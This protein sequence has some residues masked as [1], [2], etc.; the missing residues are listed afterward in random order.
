[1]AAALGAADP[2]AAGA[3]AAGGVL[4]AVDAPADGD[5]ELLEQAPTSN[6]TATARAD[7]VQSLLAMNSSS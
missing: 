4:A 6:T 5:V 1:V 7:V 3:L 2:L